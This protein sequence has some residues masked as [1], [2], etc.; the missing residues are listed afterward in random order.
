MSAFTIIW[1]KKRGFSS[2]PPSR[3][4]IRA[5]FRSFVKGLT[6]HER[7]FSIRHSRSRACWN[8]VDGCTLRHRTVTISLASRS[9]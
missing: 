5:G 3:M 4:M 6:C 8:G 7:L 1:K 9:S 2:M